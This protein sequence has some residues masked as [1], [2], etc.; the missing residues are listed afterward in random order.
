MLICLRSKRP[1]YLSCSKDENFQVLYLYFENTTIISLVQVFK[2]SQLT[3]A[4]KTENKLS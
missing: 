2:N 1:T 3:V 4:L